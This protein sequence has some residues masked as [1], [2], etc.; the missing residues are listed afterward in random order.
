MKQSVEKLLKQFYSNETPPLIL[1]QLQITN[2]CLVCKE[3]LYLTT[4]TSRETYNHK[5]SDKTKQ[6][7]QWQSEVRIQENHKQDH[8]WAQ[9]QIA[10][11]APTIEDCLTVLQLTY[12]SL[13]ILANSA[14][15]D[16][17]QQNAVSDVSTVANSHFSLR[18]SKSLSLTYLL[19]KFNSSSM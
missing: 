14:D 1:M 3:I 2:L 11:S 12:F 18:M 16:Q 19:L 7:V 9:T 13:E 5:C 10:S 17:T 6:M 8:G 4:E 15:P